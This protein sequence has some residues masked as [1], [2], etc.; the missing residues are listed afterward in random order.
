MI[1]V[2]AYEQLGI[3]PELNLIL[4]QVHISEKKGCR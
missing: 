2:N 4:G 3:S 1:D